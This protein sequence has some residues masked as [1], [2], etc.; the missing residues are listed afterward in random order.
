M[1]KKN[2]YYNALHKIRD[3]LYK[4]KNNIKLYNELH[5]AQKDYIKGLEIYAEDMTEDNLLLIH[6]KEKLSKEIERLTKLL[7]LH[8]RDVYLITSLISD[9]TLDYMLSNN[10]NINEW[11]RHQP[12]IL[13]IRG[14]CDEYMIKLDVENIDKTKKEINDIYQKTYL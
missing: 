10:I 8:N 6:E 11:T 14:Y 3:L 9:D 7:F 1:S 12:Q 5:K 4:N 13:R 2:R